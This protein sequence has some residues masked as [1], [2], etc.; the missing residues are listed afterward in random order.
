MKPFLEQEPARALFG[1]LDLDIGDVRDL[2]E[3]LDEDGTRFIDLEEFVFGCL[4][5]RGAAKAL[6]VAKLHYDG[7]RL[8]AKLY[9][10]MD[11]VSKIL[12]RLE[13]PRASTLKDPSKVM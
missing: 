10:F 1:A 6:D 7:Q 2:F 8:K 4:R 9:P 13:E 11:N 3:V 5:L 12:A